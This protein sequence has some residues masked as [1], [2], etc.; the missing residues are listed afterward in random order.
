M[1]VTTEVEALGSLGHL[2]GSYYRV[3]LVVVGTHVSGTLGD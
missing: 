2:A 1:K 3:V